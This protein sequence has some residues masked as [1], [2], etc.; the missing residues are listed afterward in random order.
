MAATIRDV[1][2]HAGVAVSTVSLVINHKKRVSPQTELKVREAIEKLNYHP[3]RSAR[4]LVTKRSGNFGFILTSDHFSR[5]EPFYTKIFLGTEFEARFHDYYVLLTTIEQQFSKR[6]IPRFLLEKNVDGVLLAGTVST[7]IIE[8]IQQMGLPYVLVDYYPPSGNHSAILI[9]NCGGIKQVVQH[10]TE[11]GHSRLAFVGADMQHPSMRER[12]QAFREA[13]LE[14]N[15]PVEDEVIYCMEGWAG[16]QAGQQ[17]VPLLLQ[18]KNPITAI[19]AA[20]DA[21]A[22]GVMRGLQERN[23]RVP[24]DIAVTGFDDVDFASTLQPSLTTL[25][26]PKEEMGALA[27]RLLTDHIHGSVSEGTKIVVP[28]QLIC[29]DSTV[30]PRPRT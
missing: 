10:L 14:R 7:K 9:D 22:S 26:V 18:A 6:Q 17:A 29:R 25:H 19:V 8:Y 23:I 20:N 15:L 24:H 27:V 5:A 13:L 3:Q 4:G 16:A 2:K 28:V 30:L 12:C 21:I 11:L 1:A